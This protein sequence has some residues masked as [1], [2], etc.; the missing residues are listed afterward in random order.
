[1]YELLKNQQC[2]GIVLKESVVFQCP[3]S[4]NSRK[5]KARTFFAKLTLSTLK[6]INVRK[7]LSRK[8]LVLREQV[9]GFEV[10]CDA[11]A[12]AMG[13]LSREFCG[14]S[15][16]SCHSC[17]PGDWPHCLAGLQEAA[18]RRISCRCFPQRLLQ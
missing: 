6:C 11:T 2:V 3:R 9:E 8:N 7:K 12:A 1:M 10:F 18:C 13:I 16:S 14:S 17:A 15:S 4:S 5:K